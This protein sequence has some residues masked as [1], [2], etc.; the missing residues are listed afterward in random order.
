M[1]NRME[2]RIFHGK[3]T[4]NE[5]AQAL[6]SEF[7]SGN[8]R[9]QQVGAGKQIIVQIG[10][11]NQPH[12][13]GHTALTVTL[14]EVEDG[15]AIQIGKQSWMGI[16]A[17]LGQTALT[18]W[19]NPWRIIDRLDD[20][21]QDVEYLQLSDQ[22][23]DIL[24]TTAENHG[25]TFELSERLRRLE[26]AYCHTANPVGEPHCVACGAPLGREQPHT[27][28]YC[29]YVVKVEE[30]VCPNCGKRL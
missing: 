12:S 10:T 27:C 18:A 26:C 23:W 24:E 21:A 29:G 15:V 13:G 16:A 22:V 19:R 2:Q 17:S 8:L 6:I 5:F 30:R 14:R 7:N 20:I 3:I 9:A 4:P 1:V 11:H 25:A 28:R